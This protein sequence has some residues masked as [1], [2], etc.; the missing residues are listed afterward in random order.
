MIVFGTI[1]A[2]QIHIVDGFYDDTFTICGLPRGRHWLRRYELTV[3]D[4]PSLCPNCVDSAQFIG[5]R[6]REL[7]Q[8]WDDLASDLRDLLETK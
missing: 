6:Y 5:E 4:L 2:G 1:L 7:A 3:K 8:E